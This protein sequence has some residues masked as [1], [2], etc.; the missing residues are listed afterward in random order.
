MARFTYTSWGGAITRILHTDPD[1]PGRFAHETSIVYADDFAQRNR[2]L[3]E[4]QA[5]TM[6]LVA[7]GVPAFVWEQAEREGWD[8]K[9]WAAW[10]NDPD[11][12]HFRVWRGR[13]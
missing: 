8:E 2:D 12:S 6:K 13:V 11:N 1:D 5:G 10:L 7:R 3:G 4:Q 9:R